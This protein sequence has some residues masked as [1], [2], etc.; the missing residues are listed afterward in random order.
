MTH[1]GCGT[2][3]EGHMV[4]FQCVMILPLVTQLKALSFVSITALL[5]SDWISDH[6][7]RH[8]T[9]RVY[10]RSSSQYSENRRVYP[11]DPC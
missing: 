6:N 2:G 10:L 7:P 4:E 11:L 8:S 3:N 9:S 5:T 1:G